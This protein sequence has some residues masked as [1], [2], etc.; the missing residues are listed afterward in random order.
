MV[1]TSFLSCESVKVYRAELEK[2]RCVANG[3]AFVAVVTGKTSVDPVRGIIFDKPIRVEHTV[4][5]HPLNPDIPVRIIAYS[6]YNAVVVISI[7]PG[8]TVYPMNQGLNRFKRTGG[9]FGLE[10]ER[11]PVISRIKAEANAKVLRLFIHDGRRKELR[12]INQPV[13]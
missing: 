2:S 8:M 7:V 3:T 12:W 6:L 13:K 5:N 10:K 4:G 1:G 11:T 9:N